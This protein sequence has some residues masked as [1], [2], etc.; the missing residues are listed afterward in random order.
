MML[1]IRTVCNAFMICPLFKSHYVYAYYIILVVSHT[2]WAISL[3]L[4]NHC[5]DIDIYLSR[6]QIH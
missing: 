4:L 6:L 5:V 1:S 3:I 2:K